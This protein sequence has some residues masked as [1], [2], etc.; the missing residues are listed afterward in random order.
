VH[1]GA[2]LSAHLAGTGRSGGPLA[3]TLAVGGIAGRACGRAFDVRTL[4]VQGYSALAPRLAVRPDGDAAARQQLRIFEIE[5]S[6]RLIS[7]A[8]K[9][10]PDGPVSIPLSP[11]SGEG[12]GCAESIRG[13]VW[14][15]LQLDHGQIAAVFPR[16]PGWALW[17]L[18]ERVMENA[19]ANDVALIRLSLALPSSGPDL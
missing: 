13:D 3:V 16:D 17:P 14:H 11:V 7:A 5:E 6:I 4:F 9:D 8:L 15:W 2:A 1:E 18:A 12:I 19:T 10:L